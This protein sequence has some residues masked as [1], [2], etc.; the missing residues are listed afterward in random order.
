MIQFLQCQGMSIFWRSGALYVFLQRL[1]HCL[2]THQLHLSQKIASDFLQQVFHKLDKEIE[3]SFYPLSNSFSIALSLEQNVL[4][5]LLQQHYNNKNNNINNT[6]N[7]SNNNNINKNS[8][9]NNSN[10]KIDKNTIS[11]KN[12]IIINLNLLP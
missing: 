6:N 12:I 4:R 8:N 10:S 11:N 1:L 2:C 3:Q 5:D 9:N 7:N